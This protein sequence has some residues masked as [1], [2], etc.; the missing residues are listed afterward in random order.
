MNN[1]RQR[2]ILCLTNED[3]SEVNDIICNKIK[4]YDE[5]MYKS[6]DTVIQEDDEDPLKRWPLEFINNMTPPGIPPHQLK[7]KV[8]TIVM[9]TK[10]IDKAQGLVNGTRMIIKNLGEEII[11]GEIIAGEF[12]GLNVHITKMDLDSTSNNWPIKFIRRQF[13]LITAFAITIN[14]SQGQT[15]DKIGIFLSKPVFNHGQLYVALSRAK[16]ENDITIYIKPS[17]VQGFLL[18]DNRLFTQNIVYQEVFD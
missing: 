11:R 9:I 3:C 8:N 16:R 15:F 12:K 10:N 4:N 2:T 1:L 13:P 5:K 17:T 6:V 18:N 7:L 14:K